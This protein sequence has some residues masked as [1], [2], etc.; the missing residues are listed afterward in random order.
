M[1]DTTNL[2]E[3]YTWNKSDVS[4][5]LHDCVYTASR[6]DYQDMSQDVYLNL[7]SSNYLSHYCDQSGE[8]RQYLIPLIYNVGHRWFEQSGIKPDSTRLR[9]EPVMPCNFEA[10]DKVWQFRNFIK[11]QEEPARSS[12]LRI[13]A[14]KCKGIPC[15]TR[16]PH[17]YRYKQVLKDFQR[18]W[19]SRGGTADGG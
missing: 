17:I 18:L 10:L 4:K 3:F 1:R 19:D 5:M 7:A 8:F 15:S 2:Q 11:K 14:L 16:Y 13:L 9:P 12:A 6:Q